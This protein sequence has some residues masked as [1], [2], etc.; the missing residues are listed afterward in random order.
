VIG[1]AI[2]LGTVALA[3]LVPALRASRAAPLEALR[4]SLAPP[5]GSR[6]TLISATVAAALGL[7][8]LLVILTASGTASERLR[9][10]AIGGGIVILAALMASPLAVPALARLVTWPLGRTG[11][12]VARLARDQ[13]IRLPGRTAVSASALTL[14]LAL[15]LLVGAYASGLRAATGDAIRQTFAGDLAVEN[16]D[17]ASSIPAASVR[18]AATVPGLVGLDS[19]KTAAAD[20]GPARAIQVNGVEPSTW[21]SVYRFDWV[22]GPPSRLASL[23]VGQILAEQDTAR[24]AHLRV[25]GPATLVTG[26]GTRVTV[27]VAGIYRD[28][29]LLRGVTLDTGWF[30]RLFHQQ[31][32]R[33]AF[34]KLGPGANRAAA[35][36]TLARSLGAFPG[37]VVRSEA[38]LAASAQRNV[39]SVI[40]LFYALL[41]LSLLM[42][43]V[44]IVGT[45]NLSVHE[46][47]R[48]LGL[49]RAL[50]LNAE[51]ARALVRDESLISAGVGSVTGVALGV[52]LSWALARALSPEGFVFSVP[53]V[54][55]VAVL[56]AGTLAGTLAAVPPGRRAARL[57]I[58]AAIAHE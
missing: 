7:G 40:G 41:A 31:R 45:L 20:L 39:S 33:A 1:L 55:L 36:A 23:G 38:Q 13:A 46:R 35:S 37:V 57:D 43:L 54:G 29:G 50:G 9:A 3:A 27:T 6:R 14:G 17:G 28:A 52:V 8:G 48:D 5:R 32:L 47:T 12:V 30:D 4:A 10:S 34:V 25:G 2:G 53:W 26:G 56:L 16:Q 18:A 11:G 58:L 19:L 42:S 21:G 49:L 44:G 15:V 51:D 22:H 24:A